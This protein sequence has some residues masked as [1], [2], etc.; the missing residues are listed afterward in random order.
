M[1]IIGKIECFYRG[2]GGE[3]G[4]AGISE[5]NRPIRYIAVEKSP[6]PVIIA[7]YAIHAREYITSYLALMQAEEF[8]KSGRKGKIYFLPAVNPDGIKICLSG[9]GLCKSNAR[10]VDLNVNFDAGWGTGEKNVTER[11]EENYIG[12]FP[13]SERETR[14]LRDFTLKIM[15][16][17]TISYHSKGEEIY[18]E[19]GQTGEN[20][21]R[22][23][24][25]ALKLAAATG[26][27][28]RIINGSAG[29]YKDWCIERLKIPSFTVEVGSDSLSH[30]IGEEF[31]EEI[32]LKNKDVMNILTESVEWK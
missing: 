22:D 21:K 18:Y 6:R 19:Y 1:D 28:A 14:A 3:K 9:R 32:F 30:P 11:G 20:L 2:Y 16:D 24:A 4:T 12:A 7:Q 25:I 27:K 31:K 17:A 10:G 8:V 5:E 15:P 26:Y 13:F 23:R 29:G